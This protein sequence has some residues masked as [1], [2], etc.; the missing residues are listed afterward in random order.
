MSGINSV[1]PAV[2]ELRRNLQT[3]RQAGIEVA[4]P[5]GRDETRLADGAEDVKLPV[6]LDQATAS[7]TFDGSGKSARTSRSLPVFHMNGP[8]LRRA[9]SMV[10]GDDSH[11]APDDKQCLDSFL[12][13]ARRGAS[14]QV[15]R[16]TYRPTLWGVKDLTET[17]TL[18]PNRSGAAVLLSHLENVWA[19]TGESGHTARDDRDAKVVLNGETHWCETA[20][21]LPNIVD[22][23]SRIE[24]GRYFPIFD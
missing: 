23:L 21:S 1:P 24:S 16:G 13:L 14:F 18:P 11:L 22:H 20:D 4:Q 3:L 7:A 5:G 19:S 9:A 12:E 6:T 8:Q 10:R 17:L 2:A 15:Q